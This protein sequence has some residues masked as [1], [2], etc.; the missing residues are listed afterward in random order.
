MPTI[1]PTIVA[2]PGAQTMPGG[3]TNQNLT[4]APRAQYVQ[5]PRAVGQAGMMNPAVQ[6]RGQMT[7]I[8]VSSIQQLVDYITL[9]L[10]L[11]ITVFISHFVK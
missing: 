6:I 9:Q 7:N 11:S 2:S 1:T 4:L 5:N 3:M 10:Q 8:M